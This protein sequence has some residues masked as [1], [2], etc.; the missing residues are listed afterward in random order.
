MNMV[1]VLA[2]QNTQSDGIG[3]F[4]SV[5]GLLKNFKIRALFLRTMP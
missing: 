4:E 2:R 3:S 5:L 1:I